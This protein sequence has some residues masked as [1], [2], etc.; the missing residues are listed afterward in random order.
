MAWSGIIG[1]VIFENWSDSGYEKTQGMTMEVDN[2]SGKDKKAL[3]VS[4][5]LKPKEF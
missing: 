2:L 3:W 5:I 1:S 4:E